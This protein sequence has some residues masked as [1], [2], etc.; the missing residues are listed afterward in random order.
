MS[1]VPNHF[2][3]ATNWTGKLKVILMNL[4]QSSTSKLSWFDCLKRIFK[5]QTCMGEESGCTKG[6]GDGCIQERRH[7]LSHGQPVLFI[8]S[9]LALKMSKGR[10]RLVAVQQL[11][12][13]EAVLFKWM[14][15]HCHSSGYI[16]LRLCLSLRAQ[17]KFVL[18]LEDHG[19]LHPTMGW[20]LHLG[21]MVVSLQPRASFG[22]VHTGTSHFTL[23]LCFRK[24][25]CISKT[26]NLKIIF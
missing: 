24:A 3:Q 21:Q 19:L 4:H 22:T 1:S 7:P 9:W 26:G 16:L 6:S 17:S 14:L 15:E 2:F 23:G 10:M 20:D 8:W 18:F 25:A 13:N 12:I 11:L 5:R